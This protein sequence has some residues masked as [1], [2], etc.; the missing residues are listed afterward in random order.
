M[1]VTYL[2]NFEVLEWQEVARTETINNTLNPNFTKKVRS[3]D[4]KTYMRSEVPTMFSNKTGILRCD[5]LD[6][7]D[8][9]YPSTKFHGILY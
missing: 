6:D 3:K 5:A 4:C 1:C 2:K 8:S 9:R 7:G